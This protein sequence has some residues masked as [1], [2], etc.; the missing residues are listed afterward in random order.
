LGA[1]IPIPYSYLR[2]REVVETNVLGTLNVVNAARSQG[3]VRVVHTST[4]ETYGTARYVPIDEAH[5]LQGQSPY[6]ASKIAADKIVESF[7]LSYD[8]PAV[9]IRPF[10]TFGPRQST[11]AIIPT[12]ITQALTMD[13]ILVGDLTPTRDL[14]FVQNLVEAFLA[15]GTVDK[16]IGEVINVGTGIEISIGDLAQKIQHLTGRDVP[17]VKDPSRIRPA[18]SEVRQLLAEIEKARL[19]L[20]WRPSVSLED[21]LEQ[22]IRWISSNIDHYNPGTYHV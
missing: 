7:V 13:Q 20:D 10:N 15:A 3:N 21:G 14:N 18:K 17:L 11:R 1:I 2:P 9:T 19:I 8:L 5:P 6:A 22:T 4:S 12:L 16:A